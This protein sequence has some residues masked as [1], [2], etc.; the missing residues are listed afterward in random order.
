[1][2]SVAITGAVGIAGVAGTI[3]AAKLGARTATQNV[4]LSV[5]AEDRR[6]RLADKRQIYARA[7]TAVDIAVR[8]AAYEHGRREKLGTVDATAARESYEALLRAGEA[9]SELQLLASSPV[10]DASVEAMAS[11]T[12]FRE[13]KASLDERKT[14]DAYAKTRAALW[15]ALRADL[16]EEAGR[17]D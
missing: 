13:D 9:L 12:A 2:I 15:A 6:A 17:G 8:R 1:M 10:I 16:E 7:L 3:T 5:S 11:L 4:R 14:T